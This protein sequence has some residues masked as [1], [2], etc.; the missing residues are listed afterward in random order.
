[1][2]GSYT[3]DFALLN[4]TFWVDLLSQRDVS[5]Q[6]P[7]NYVTEPSIALTAACFGD[8]RYLGDAGSFCLSDLLTV[9]YRRFIID[10]Y[11]SPSNRQWLLCP[12]S[13]PSNSTSDDSPYRLGNYT[14]S[15]T[16]N[17]TT[18]MED[19][20]SYI[21]SSSADIDST[22]LYIVFN[23]HVAADSNNP[24]QPASIVSS[25]D[26]PSGSLLLG[27]ISNNA[28]DSFI[29]TPP[30]L[31]EER[32]NLNDSW[33][34]GTRSRTTVLQ[35]Y[36]TTIRQDN[37]I[38]ST[39]D[40]WP[41]LAYLINKRAKRLILGRGSIDP[42]LQGYNVSGDEPYIFS[43]NY[44]EDAINVSATSAGQGLQFGCF[45]NPQ[46]TDPKNLNNSWAL[47]TL[48]E[49]GPNISH[50]TSLL[51]K[52]YTGCGITPVINHT[53]GGQSAD[54]GVDP[55]RNLSLST[56]WSW[57]VGEPRNAS[58]LPG[59]EEIAP[60]SDILR[61]AMM[62]P[63][64]NGHWR[65]GNCSDTYRAACRVD[66]R[67]Y[68]WVLSDSRQSFAD[69]NKICSNG[70]SFDVPRTG[71]ENTYL[72]H[73]VLSASDTPNEPVWINLNSIDVQY[74]W[75]LGGANATCIYIADADNVG[76]KTVLVPT[77]AAIIILV[78]TAATLFVKC[79]SNRRISRR[80]RVNQG[81]DYEG[82]PS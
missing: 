9:G 30:E 18:I 60:S 69:S 64:S 25:A 81:W 38:L 82:V 75:V 52:N 35:E 19:L 43:T 29:Y 67:P 22:F 13:I 17:L 45:Y 46:S 7:I 76:R 58:S 50:S 61:C 42:Q 78:I 68:S 8:N 21:R 4:S 40:G 71:L 79:N 53:L 59:Y 57:A 55:Y 10:V 80:K 2:S 12:V 26:L 56:M 62:D 6:V 74:C 14:C 77:I 27:E 28:L 23:I 31:A 63:T 72:Y 49:I 73:T 39:P 66:S 33:Y 44:I 41:C 5:A 20:R 47:S 65:A 11:W 3:S 24:D 54:I 48:N 1:M 51:L 16:F 37:H 36:F 70:S 15:G 32:S 34:H